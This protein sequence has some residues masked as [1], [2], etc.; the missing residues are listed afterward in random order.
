MSFREN[1]NK[2]HFDLISKFEVSVEEC[3][4]KA[5]NYVKLLVKENNKQLVVNITK[6]SLES[7]V[8]N[9]TYSS[10]PLNEDSDNIERTSSVDGFLNDV[11]DVFEKNRFSEDYLKKLS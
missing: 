10:N 8:F 6:S 1:I 9:W 5:G 2:L 7:N 11:S 4:N 3:Q